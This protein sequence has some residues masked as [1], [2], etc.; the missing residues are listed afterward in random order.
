[1]TPLINGVNHSWASIKINMLGRTVIGVSKITYDDDTVLENNYGAGNMPVS[2]GVGN[3]TAKASI[4]LHQAETVAIQAAALQNG[5]ERVQDIP[6]FDVVVAYVPTG[7]NQLVTDVIKNC[8]FKTNGRDVSQ[9]DTLIKH[10]HELVVS[11]IIWGG[12]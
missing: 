11:H 8:Q 2:R 1:M 3:Y 6:P 7:S 12:Q 4:E 10:S 5:I 9:G